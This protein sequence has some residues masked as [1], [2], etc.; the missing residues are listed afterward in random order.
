[1]A[2]VAIVTGGSSG[3]G[4]HTAAQL[5][6]SG[7]TVYSFSRRPHEQEG[8]RH[9]CVDVTDEKQ[10]TQAVAKVL[11]EQ[12]R[13]DILV[14]CA[15]FGISGAAEFTDSKASH[16]Q[17]EV[18]LFGTDNI[19]RAVLP[20]MR[21][22]HQGRIVCISSVAG[23]VSIP[24]QLWYSVSKAA[25]NAYILGLQNEVRPFGIR[26]CA[27][28]PG[29]I[30]TGF[31]DAREKSPIG[32]EIYGGRIAKSVAVMEKDERNGMSAQKAGKFVARYALKKNSK[33]L[34]IMGAS[35]QAVGLLVRVLPT[36][37]ANWIVGK[38]YG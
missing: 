2:K 29:D 14:S 5:R 1:M 28:L 23:I 3:I 21:K 20:Q 32:D 35:Y 19:V 10:V 36:R 12:G 26:I 24:F 15:G 18:N 25:I 9:I 16:A 4:L 38:I 30:A 22:Q 27:I 13:I 7:C 33:P 34:V 8:I 17:L 6:D 31:T 37:A 11:D